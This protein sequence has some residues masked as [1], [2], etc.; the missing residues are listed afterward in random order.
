[1]FSHVEM[2][3]RRKSL[4]SE[5]T[6]MRYRHYGY[7]CWADAEHAGVMLWAYIFLRQTE[8]LRGLA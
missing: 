4:T 7:T 5:S 1:M 3:L 8:D 2:Q 6:F